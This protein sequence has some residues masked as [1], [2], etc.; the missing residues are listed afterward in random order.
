MYSRLK[1]KKSGVIIA[2]IK[3]LLVVYKI[4]Y[5]LIYFIVYLI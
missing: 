1:I 3:Y 5:I 4:I 2:K